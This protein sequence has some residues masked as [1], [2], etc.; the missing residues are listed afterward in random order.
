MNSI[1]I[2]NLLSQLLLFLIALP[3]PSVFKC[4][5]TYSSKIGCLTYSIQSLGPY[6]LTNK[7]LGDV[8]IYNCHQCE[9]GYLLTK[10]SKDSPNYKCLHSCSQDSCAECG[11]EE[12]GVYICMECQEL[13]IFSR[14]NEGECIPCPKR[15]LNCSSTQIG[16]N[17][18]EGIGSDYSSP[19][20]NCMATLD[21]HCGG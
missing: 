15:C 10:Y 19:C 2:I 11:R 3:T 6:Q 1:K 21:T 16:C 14:E 20:I 17:C 12:N 8:C 9:K 7:Y 13:Y 5:T 18:T 4:K